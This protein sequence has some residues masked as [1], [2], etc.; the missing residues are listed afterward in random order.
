MCPICGERTIVALFRGRSPEAIDGPEFLLGQCRACGLVRIDPQPS[1]EQLASA[2]ED[3]YCGEL[4]RADGSVGVVARWG[5]RAFL[6]GRRRRIERLR[7]G[8]RL[9]DVGCGTGDF[10]HIMHEAGWEVSGVEPNVEARRRVPSPLRYRVVETID[11]VTGGP[12]DVITLWHVLEHMPSPGLDIEKL[13]ALLSPGGVL[14]IAVPNFGS[15]EAAIAGSRWFHLDVPRHLYHFTPDTLCRLVERHGFRVNHINFFSWTYNVFGSW[16]TLLNLVVP[17]PNYL[18]RRWKQRL[19]RSAQQS[20]WRF[21]Y[22]SAL[23]YVVAP[24]AA[25]PA[26]AISA[27][28]APFGRS[29]TME[30]EAS[31]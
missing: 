6:Q 18:Y 29:G 4:A 30:V 16:Q 2:Y 28:S 31:R 10:L 9:L 13:N 19:R 3:Q 12:F 26:L 21:A 27:I 11:H 15:W 23:S 5:G 20:P 8:R 14:F 25:I 24:A 1:E 7:R 17:E 22:C